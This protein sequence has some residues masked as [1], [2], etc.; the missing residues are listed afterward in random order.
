MSLTSY[1]VQRFRGAFA[2][3][4]YEGDQRHRRR[5]YSTDRLSAEAEARQLW[6]EADSAP[7]TV[8]RIVIGYIDK[9][10]ETAPP[11]LQ[12]RRDAWKAMRSYWDNVDPS[13]IDDK[14]CEGYHKARAVSDATSRY[15]LQLLSTALE[16]AKGKASYTEKPKV[17]LPPKPE[18]QIRHLSHAQFEAFFEAVRA[19]HARLYVLLGLYTMARPTALLDL[20]WE[21]VDFDLRQ[22]D[23]NPSGRRQTIKFRPIVAINDALFE[24]L[25]DAYAARQ[26]Q[27]VIE[28]GGQRI[29]NIKKAFQA[30][31]SRC[32]F[33]VTPYMLRHTGAVWAAEAGT[34]MAELAQFMGHD[35]DRTTQKHY[36]RYSPGHLKKAAN[37]VQRRPRKHE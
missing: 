30:A 12:R 26:T 6:Q 22:I 27:H 11:S 16:W 36:A 1:S 3:V 17:W 13:R 21:Q 33:R 15:E 28:R 4:W 20:T 8:G 23:L 2:M 14:M 31:S 32:G 7:W 37:S 5:L 9:L 10:A 25:I 29:E 19:P 34:S 24:V 18:R 35:D